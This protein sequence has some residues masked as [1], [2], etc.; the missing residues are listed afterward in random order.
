MP[1]KHHL[2]MRWRTGFAPTAHRQ[3]I[4][5]PNVCP[6]LTLFSNL[7]RIFCVLHQCYYHYCHYCWL[8]LK[9]DKSQRRGSQVDTISPIDVFVSLSV[10]ELRSRVAE[11]S[12][13]LI[14][15]TVISGVPPEPIPV[16]PVIDCLFWLNSNHNINSSLRLFT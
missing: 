7:N 2:S 15:S 14:S 11:E 10:S 3:S 13:L 4:Q 5:S 8:S 12:C 16:R 9:R 1:V 6:K